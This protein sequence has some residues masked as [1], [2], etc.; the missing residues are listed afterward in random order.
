M[1]L[2]LVRASWSTRRLHARGPACLPDS[3]TCEPGESPDGHLCVHP[4]RVTRLE[5]ETASGP[6]AVP[7]QVDVVLHPDEHLLDLNG[8][9]R[10]L[11][12]AVVVHTGLPHP[13]LA[14]SAHVPR[15]ATEGRRRD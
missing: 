15:P 7:R 6:R 5:P 8:P 10:L 11:P 9:D 12:N 13:L 4:A 2:R 14:E 3:G 1:L